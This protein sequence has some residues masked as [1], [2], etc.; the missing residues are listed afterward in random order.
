MSADPHLPATPALRRPESDGR[1][2]CPAGSGQGGE[3][4]H[5]S[6]IGCTVL[7]GMTVSEADQVR[8][9]RLL[10]TVFASGRQRERVRRLAERHAP[11]SLVVEVASATDAVLT[12]L[13]GPLD[14]VLVDA[15]LVGDLLSALRRHAQRSSPHARVVVFGGMST[16]ADTGEAWPGD[17]VPWAQLDDTLRRLLQGS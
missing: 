4:V 11:G 8:S 17:V 15:G 10:M 5:G 2:S 16:D 6:A 12:L 1:S 3:R 13:A 9:L 14:L 7:G